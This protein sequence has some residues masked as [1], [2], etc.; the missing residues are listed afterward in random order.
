MSD[1]A[2]QKLRE[3]SAARLKAARRKA[4]YSSARSAARSLRFNENTYKAHES[5]RN[6]FGLADAKQYADAFRVSAS[7]LLTGSEEAP[8]ELD[9]VPLGSEFQPDPDF[10]ET[11]S[12][13]YSPAAPYTPSVPGAHPEIDVRAGAGLGTVGAHATLAIEAGGTVTG[14]AV[15]GEWVFPTTFTRNELHATPSAVIFMAVTGDSMTPTL[16]PNDRIIV[17]T[18]ARAFGADGV[19]VIDDGDGEPRVKRLTKVLFSSPP[20]V[21]IVSDNPAHGEQTVELARIR[22]IGRVCG[23]VSRL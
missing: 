1:G 4:G 5:G 14:H 16:L 6:G 7:W 22:V 17:D 20:Q 19:Y 12:S 23:R 13:G 9:R 21:V 11:L 10:D 18:A 2:E 8:R 3:E 15:V